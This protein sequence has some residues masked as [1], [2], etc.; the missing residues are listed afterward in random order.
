MLPCALSLLADSNAPHHDD[1]GADV[2][3]DH[4]HHQAINDGRGA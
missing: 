4:G 1:D 3:A 2:V